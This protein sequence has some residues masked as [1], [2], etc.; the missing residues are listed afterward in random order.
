MEESTPDL[1]IMSVATRLSY[2]YPDVGHT[3]VMTTFSV[4]NQCEFPLWSSRTRKCERRTGVAFWHPIPFD[5]NFV[6]KVKHVNIEEPKK[7]SIM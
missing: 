2:Q 3:I 1:S 5:L 7:V 6:R 4:P